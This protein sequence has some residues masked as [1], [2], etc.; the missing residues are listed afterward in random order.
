MPKNVIQ[1]T[2]KKAKDMEMQTQDLK[3]T[4]HLIAIQE[5]MAQEQKIHQLE[6]H[7]QDNQGMHKM[8]R[9]QQVKQMQQ[10]H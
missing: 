4:I 3:E 10:I 2:S 1:R 5:E 6:E 8:Q 7:Q 9:K